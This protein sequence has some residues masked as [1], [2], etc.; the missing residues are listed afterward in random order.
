MKTEINLLIL[1]AGKGSRYGSEKQFDGV[2][3]NGEFLFEYS[4]Y[5]AIQIGFS[6]IVIITSKES[7][8][9]IE[10]YLESR[11]SNKIRFCCIAQ[12]EK[13][14]PY[15][16]QV[17]IERTKPW[18]T[19]HAVWSGR[20][21]LTDSDSFVT[22]NADDFYTRE[23]LALAFKA[24]KNITSDTKYGLVA[25]RLQKTLSINGPV[26]RGICDLNDSELIKINEC[27][28]L[29]DIEGVIIDKSSNTQFTGNELVSMNLWV[30]TPD[31]FKTIERQFAIFISENEDLK[32][33]E[34]Y[35]PSV[36]QSEIDNSENTVKVIANH[37]EWMGMTYASDREGVKS[38]LK[39]FVQSG[40]YPRD[41]WA[42]L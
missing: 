41:L 7:K 38:R 25:F 27:T 9:E 33:G 18:G 29:I 37:G 30:L 40:L 2:G 31:V 32:S 20:E 23:A 17:K 21:V 5:D 6:N 16:S 39:S 24:S 22:I 14:I 35:L 26:S 11:I 28:Q 8:Q 15:N 10:D 4:I 36:I 12:E 13:D 42:T 1:A 34:I 3:V 19:A